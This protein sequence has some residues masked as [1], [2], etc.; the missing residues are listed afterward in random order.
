VWIKTILLSMAIRAVAVA[1]IALVIA[2]G[3]QSSL[4]NTVLTSE[5]LHGQHVSG[6]TPLRTPVPSLAQQTALKHKFSIFIHYSICKCRTASEDSVS[7]FIH[8][9]LC[10]CRT[11]SKDSVSIFIHYSLC[12][13]R[14]ASKDSVSIFI[15]YSLCECRTASK[16]SVLIRILRVGV[17]G[18]M[19]R[20]TQPLLLILAWLCMV[21]GRHL[22]GLPVE[23]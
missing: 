3:A 10:E 21:V 5:A 16:D 14:T 9:S 13:C 18:S 6:A 15:H 7:I 8:Y 11:A 19:H 23:P 1:V 17:A 2:A 4:R 12:E 20:L 22:P